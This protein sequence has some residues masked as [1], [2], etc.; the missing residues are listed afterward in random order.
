L[1]EY[2]LESREAVREAV[3]REKALE[4]RMNEEIKKQA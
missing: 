4:A 2:V 3:E 1:E